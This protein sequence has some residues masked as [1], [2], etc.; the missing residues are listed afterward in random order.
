[1]SLARAAN[2]EPTI[3]V[4]D[5]I[6]CAPIQLR[7]NGRHVGGGEGGNHETAQCRRKNRR[8]HQGLNV[9]S[10]LFC[11]ART[12]MRIEHK[13]SQRGKD[14]WPRPQRVMSQVEPKRCEYTVS[15]ILRR[16]D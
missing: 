7:A 8:I 16:K 11:V 12:Q 2:D 15:F 13:R 3:E 1:M 4:V 5:D 14:P 9:T 6:R 10:S